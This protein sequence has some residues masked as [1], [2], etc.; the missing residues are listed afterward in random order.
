MPQLLHI[1]ICTILLLTISPSSPK[2]SIPITRS[3]RTAS[4]FLLNAYAAQSG[5][6]GLNQANAGFYVDVDLTD[7][8]SS[9]GSS[10]SSDAD[11]ANMLIALYTSN[12]L[13]AED[14]LAFFDYDCSM[15]PSCSPQ[16]NTKSSLAYPYFYA[17][18]YYVTNQVYMDYQYWNLTTR[19][20]VA[21]RC[22]SNASLTYGIETA[23]ILGMGATGNSSNNYMTSPVFGIYLDKSGQYGELTFTD[24]L[25]YVQSTT[26]VVNMSSNS[27]WHVN[28]VTLVQLS[29]AFSFPQSNLSIIFDINADAIGLPLQLYN[30]VINALTTIASVICPNNTYYAPTCAYTDEIQ[31][32][33][34]IQITVQSQILNI[35]PEAY[36]QGAEFNDDRSATGN[37]V[38]NLRALDPSLDGNSYVTPAYQSFIILDSN[39]MMYYYTLFESYASGTGA[40][41]MYVALPHTDNV[42]MYVFI[43]IAVLLVTLFLAWCYIKRKERLK[44]EAEEYDKLQEEQAE[45][46][47]NKP[48]ENNYRQFPELSV[49]TGYNNPF[50]QL[51]RSQQA[52]QNRLAE[53]LDDVSEH[54]YQPPKMESGSYKY[55][56]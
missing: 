17:Y 26:P 9:G 56:L 55:P 7:E 43:G 48:V 49:S 54:S 30:Q 29:S 33:P 40:I 53:Q 14:C 22:N 41:T 47:E 45:E 52:E 39:V 6:V 24:D 2:D 5:P 32:L 3:S 28:G 13:F 19:A 46:N 38:L 36:V 1:L 50:A 27:D 4:P 34:D 44:K 20:T 31:N 35:P 18:G 12:T 11:S 42:A 10:E 51:Q 23:G 25:T 21:T 8:S 16:N 37:I 15:Y